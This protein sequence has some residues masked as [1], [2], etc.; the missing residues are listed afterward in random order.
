MSKPSRWSVDPASYELA[1]HFAQGENLTE[2]ELKELS[3]LIQDTVEGYFTAR[4]ERI[5][6][7]LAR[8][9]AHERERVDA[10]FEPSSEDE[11]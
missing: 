3:Q 11:S 2:D 7:D 1:E 10:M 8:D 4:P 5:D 9:D 6:V